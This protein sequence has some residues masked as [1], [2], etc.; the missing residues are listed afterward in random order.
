MNHFLGRDDDVEFDRGSRQ[1]VLNR[2]CRDAPA[3]WMAFLQEE[4]EWQKNPVQHTTS[5]Q[6][7]GIRLGPCT[8]STPAFREKLAELDKVVPGSDTPA[9]SH[10]VDIHL[11]HRGQLPP[12]SHR[13]DPESDLKFGD[14]VLCLLEVDGSTDNRGWDI[15]QVV[16]V[17]ETEVHIVYQQPCRRVRGSIWAGE[18]WKHRLGCVTREDDTVWDDVV[19]KSSVCWAGDLTADGKIRAREVQTFLGQLG[20]IDDFHRGKLSQLD[21]LEGLPGYPLDVDDDG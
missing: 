9:P 10:P 6:W 2:K 3:E 14:V 15:G 4:E 19:K 11:Y 5:Q 7:S 16:E 12:A 20:R 1:E 13:F 18:W 8:P 21:I 17:L